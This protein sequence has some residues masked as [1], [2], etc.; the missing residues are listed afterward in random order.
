[1]SKFKKDWNPYIFFR[2]MAMTIFF[3][4]SKFK[5]DWNLACGL[6]NGE[7]HTIFPHVQIQEGLK[8]LNLQKHSLWVS[9]FPMSKFKKDWNGAEGQAT[10]PVISIFPHVQIQEGLKHFSTKVVTSLG[11][12]FPH[13]QIQEGLKLRALKRRAKRETYFSPCPNSRRIETWKS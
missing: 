10:A 1:M 6:H 2:R 7:L 9:F 12:I 11:F 13:V 8:P 3:P 4:M 5:K